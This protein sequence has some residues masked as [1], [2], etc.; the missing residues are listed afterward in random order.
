MHRISVTDGALTNYLLNSDFRDTDLFS[1][2]VGFERN[3]K[4]YVYAN[5]WFTKSKSFSPPM[6][7]WVDTVGDE[8]GVRRD[9]LIGK[10]L[11]DFIEIKEDNRVLI[12]DKKI[13]LLRNFSVTPICG[14]SIL[15][16]TMCKYYVYRPIH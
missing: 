3:H 12:S 8:N 7:L 9:V 4:I 10:S 15:V 1:Y 11:E 2:V 6:D 5:E 14:S 13:E 16:K